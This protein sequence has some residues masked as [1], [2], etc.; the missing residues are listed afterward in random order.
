MLCHQT[1]T[2]QRATLSC[3][4]MPGSHFF[5]TSSECE[6]SRPDP[7]TLH[8][9]S[10]VLSAFCSLS[11][12]LSALCSLFNF[13]ISL[14]KIIALEYSRQASQPD[15]H[16]GGNKAIH[17]GTGSICPF[18]FDHFFCGFVYNRVVQENH[19]FDLAL[20]ILKQA[21]DKIRTSVS[22][23]EPFCIRCAL[24]FSSF[25]YSLKMTYFIITFLYLVKAW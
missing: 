17:C 21:A 2:T 3:L 19:H 9:P 24:H 10:M 1:T 12:F 18:D 25:R 6:V 22:A 16:S 4:S 15:A 14:L 23:E 7:S 5:T 8:I 20:N 13:R 11:L